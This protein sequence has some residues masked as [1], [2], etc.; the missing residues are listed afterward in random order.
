MK[1]IKGLLLFLI[2]FLFACILIFTFTQ[3]PFK[4][5]VPALIF[6]YRTPEI[7]IYIYV[8]GAFGVGLLIGLCATLYYYIVLQT[9]IHAKSKELKSLQEQLDDSRRAVVTAGEGRFDD[10]AGSTE[11]AGMDLSLSKG[12]QYFDEPPEGIS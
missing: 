6:A 3:E 8:A 5:P 4:Q 7:P 9:K 1:F 11:S 2:A 10:S 12:E